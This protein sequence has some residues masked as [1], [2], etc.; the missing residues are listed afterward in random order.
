MAAAVSR[1]VTMFVKSLDDDTY[2]G[3]NGVLRL[4][5][6]GFIAPLTAF[7]EPVALDAVDVGDMVQVLIDSD[8]YPLQVDADGG[9]I[10]PY[11]Q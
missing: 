5:G 2:T 4:A 7:V 11:P 6:D 3:G 1:W 10:W 9:R 8:D